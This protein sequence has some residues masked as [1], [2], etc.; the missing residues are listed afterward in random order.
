MFDLAARGM[1]NILIAAHLN[2]LRGTHPKYQPWNGREWTHDLV[3]SVLS[4]HAV[5]GW[6]QPHRRVRDAKRPVSSKDK[7]RYKHVP[8]GDLIRDYFPVVIG[9]DLWNRAQA[10]RAK[11]ARTKRGR[12]SN[13]HTNI[14]SGILNCGACG[15]SLYLSGRSK[16]GAYLKCRSAAQGGCQHGNG[17]TTGDIED[18]VLLRALIDP[19]VAGPSDFYSAATAEADRLAAETERLRQ[20]VKEETR[21]YEN[22]RRNANDAEDERE[23]EDFRSDARGHKA[24]LEK[25]DL[26]L[27]ETER[28]LTFVRGNDPFTAAK[29]MM[30]LVARRNDPEVRAELVLLTRRLFSRVTIL[31]GV[32]T[33]HC[34]MGIGT[35]RLVVPGLTPRAK[36]LVPVQGQGEPDRLPSP[37]NWLHDAARAFIAEHL[38]DDTP[39]GRRNIRAYGMLDG[40]LPGRPGAG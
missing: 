40:L 4:N 5:R 13:R 18:A 37:E 12:P 26:A 8:E 21:R 14:F 29:E 39:E 32:L 35:M 15:K 22:A 1:G 23:A 3:D 38:H 24:E 11:D 34:A 9:D 17:Y 16:R 10:A 6:F 20:V 33:L 25:A 27:A 2:G 28:R 31:N 36:L 19:R 30:R 7:P